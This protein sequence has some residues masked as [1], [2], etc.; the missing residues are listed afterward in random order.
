MKRLRADSCRPAG[1][2]V[3]IIFSAC[4]EFFV[5]SEWAK[6]SGWRESLRPISLLLKGKNL[7]P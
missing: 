3:T 6:L 5:C 4:H 2:D 1:E 7:R